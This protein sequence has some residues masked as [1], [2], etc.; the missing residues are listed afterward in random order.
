MGATVNLTTKFSDKVAERISKTSITEGA[1]S[2]DYNFTGVKTLEVYS[3]DTVALSNYNRSASSNRYGTPYELGDTLQSLEMTQDKS[4]TYII[5]KGNEAEQMNIKGANKSLKREID[6]VIVPTLDKYRL[7]QWSRKAGSVKSL[8]AVNNN[9]IIGL[10]MDCTEKLDNALVPETGRI[11]YIK[12]SGYKALKQAPN[13]VYTSE[14]AQDSLVKGQVGEIDG[15]KVIKVPSSYLPEG[16][17]WLITYKSAILAPKKLADYKIHADPPGISG[18]LVE[19]RIMHDAF[20]LGSKGNAVCVGVN[21]NYAINAPTITN[22]STNSKFVIA[23]T[24]AGVDVYYTTDGSDPRYSDSATSLGAN[25]GIVNFATLNNAA[26]DS[27][28][29]V[30]VRAA[31]L[32]NSNASLFW[33]E[34]SAATQYS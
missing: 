10:I 11:M 9:S 1:A 23:S 6:E 21:A 3:V 22:D 25:S 28:Q 8:A 31:A 34:V 30:N 14:L 16:V 20:I 29:H 12:T 19:G 5:D 24:T 18:N 7:E 33:S 15:M 13:F 27:N 32:P 26:T 2:Q 17:E 4:F